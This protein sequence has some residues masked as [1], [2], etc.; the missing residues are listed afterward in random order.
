MRKILVFILFFLVCE[1][2][3]ASES[4]ISYLLINDVEERE[5]EVVMNKEQMYLPCKYILGFLQ[6]PYKENHVE[7]SLYFK[8][9][10]IKNDSVYIDGLKQNYQSFFINN[11]I[12]GIKNEF[13]LPAEPLAQITG[14]N[15]TSNPKQLMAFIKNEELVQKAQGFDDN[16]FIVKEKKPS[17]DA[18]PELV[19]PNSKGWITLDSVAFS[20]NMMSDSYSQIYRDSKN[21]T[22]SFANNSKAIMSGRVKSGE[23]KLEMGANSYTNNPFSFS[24][25]SPQYKNKSGRYDYI[26]GK[27]DSWSLGQYGIGNDVMGFQIKDHVE[28]NSNYKDI[29]GYVSP[30]ST[31][32]VYINDNFEKELSTYGGF[33][34][35]KD[36]YYNGMVKKVRVEELMA[37]GTKKEVLTREFKESQEKNIPENDIILG[38]AG[39]QNRFWAANGC[40]YQNNTKKFVSGGKYSQQINDKLSFENFFLMDKIMS[41][42]DSS[43][44]GRSILGNRKYLNFTTMKNTNMLEG[45][46]YM[47][48]L[49]YK[50]NEKLSS[51]LYFGFSN[52]MSADGITPDGKGFCLNYENNWQI[53]DNNSLKSSFFAYSPDFYMAGSTSGS[54][55]FLSDRAGVSFSGN[56]KIKNTSISGSYSRYASNFGG[57]YEGGL[58]DFD[59]YNFIARSNFKV[60]PSMMFRMNA[61][62]GSNCL[63]KIASGCYELSANKRMKCF[64]FNGG[65]RNNYYS[66][67]YRQG[68]YSSYD[69]EY[70]TVYTDVSFPLGKRFGSMNIDHEIVTANSETVDSNYNSIKLGYSTPVMKGISLNVVGGY[71]YTGLNKGLDFSAGVMKRLKSGS[72]LSLNYRFNRT[73][74]YIVDNMYVP[75]N[76]RHSVTVDFSELYGLADGWFK[77]LGT[78]NMNK[79]YFQASAFLDVNKNGIQEKGEPDIENIPIKIENDSDVFFT[80]KKGKTNLKPEDSGVYRVEIA[81]DNLPT[82]LSVHNK[83][84]PV[85]YVK[86][87]EKEKTETSFGLISSVGNINGTVTVRDEY[88]TPLNVKDI[89]VSIIDN[90][91]SEINYTNINEDGSFSVSG[92]SPGKYFVE[93]DKGLQKAYNIY[94]DKDS[95]NYTVEIPPEYKDYVN[96]DNVNLNYRYKI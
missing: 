34:S 62:K 93:V 59:E 91:G 56:T 47:G 16:P 22:L 52:S 64:N 7:K 42:P 9:A 33:Y 25:I 6:I 96:I 57:I 26:C 78:N 60:A 27:V 12:T 31:V 94:P 18:H 70:S 49:S 4:I 17:V 11:G 77:A 24:G 10:C 90:D 55:G 30:K 87:N 44:W 58:M 82:F 86:I 95:E 29:Q 68:G 45:Q 74:C 5:I 89:V 72:A 40:L 1:Y 43:N 38:L 63:G 73:P 83:S 8:N 67:K 13:F 28:K 76:M 46:T 84:N 19:L 37:D 51:D 23:Y 50:N 80:A 36:V 71:H 92:V 48:L 85:R 66:N 75:S 61:K 69:S 21:T 39:I 79:G 20:N 41:L 88:D 3:S 81:E 53:N 2:C 32:K 14:E 15:I 35:L 54:G 65:I